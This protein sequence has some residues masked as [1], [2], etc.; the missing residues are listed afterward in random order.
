MTLGETIV[1]MFKQLNKELED[2]EKPIRLPPSI[3]EQR[4]QA[5]RA[6][7]ICDTIDETQEWD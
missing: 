3:K 1:A 4:E 7:Y 5:K 6:K 2:A